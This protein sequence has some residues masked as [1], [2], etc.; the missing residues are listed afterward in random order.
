MKCINCGANF[1]TADLK[2][3]YCGTQNSIGEEWQKERKWHE[4]R[5][6]RILE[7]LKEYGPAY[8]VNRIINKALIIAIVIFIVLT[9]VYLLPAFIQDISLLAKRTFLGYSINKQ[10]EEYHESGQWDKLLDIVD[11]YDLFST[12][13]YTYTQAAILQR[14]YEDYLMH[15]MGF[16]D[17]SEEEKQE[18][19]YYLEY[20][21]RDSREVYFV[22]CGIY[23]EIDEENLPQIEKY[24]QE[25]HAFWKV[26][27]G[28]TDEEIQYFTEEESISYEEMDEFVIKIKERKAWQ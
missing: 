24:R 3:P 11:E 27:L 18:D 19:D 22:S 2:C 1:Q 14:H 9:L 28:L 6:Q 15:K 21:I 25:I 5:Y 13:S 26:T 4:N 12:D 8:V 10:M 23:S 17:L 16:L 7:E 20:A